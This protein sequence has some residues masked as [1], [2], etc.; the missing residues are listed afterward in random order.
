MKVGRFA[1]RGLIALAIFIPA[2]AW[3]THR[4]QTRG[5]DT[6]PLQGAGRW[7]YLAPLPHTRSEVAVTEANGEVYMLRGY[8]DG[9][10][11][12]P[13]NEEH[14]PATN[15]WRSPAPM[16]WGLNHVG[17]VG[18]GG[19]IYCIGWFVEQNKTSVADVVV[20]DP[21]PISGR[22]ERLCPWARCRSRHST[23]KST[24]S[25]GAMAK[26][27]QHVMSTIHRQIAGATWL[28]YLSHAIIWVW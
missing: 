4:V 16:P 1:V 21:G 11:D 22:N 19:K 27:S 5:P 8:A 28:Q 23:E 15:M 9:F 3:Q 17:A 18:L 13:L 7:R 12:Q 14:G 25:A 6:P 20:Y 26:A 10:V 24:L 2:F